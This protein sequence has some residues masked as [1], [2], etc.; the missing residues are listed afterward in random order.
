[1]H[2]SCAICGI[3][4]YAGS[5]K[6]EM[7]E[8]ALGFLPKFI[9]ANTAC[10]DTLIAQ[11]TRHVREVCRRAAK[12]AALRKHVPEKLAETYYREIASS[13][14][15]KRGARGHLTPQGTRINGRR[16]TK[17]LAQ[18]HE[19]GALSGSPSVFGVVRG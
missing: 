15:G 1:L 11:K 18:N 17:S 10:N 2:N 7:L 5:A 14:T 3:E 13:G 4:L 6:T 19:R 16:T 12:L 9:A 8:A